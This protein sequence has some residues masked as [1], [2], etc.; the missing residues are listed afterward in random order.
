MM[1]PGKVAATRRRASSLTGER[2][3]RDEHLGGG[4]RAVAGGQAEFARVG[5]VEERGGLEGHEGD[6]TRRS[7]TSGTGSPPS[8]C[9]SMSCS[10]VRTQATSANFSRAASATSSVARGLCA[11]NGSALARQQG[12]AVHHLGRE[13]LGGG[14]DVDLAV[15]GGDDERGTGGRAPAKSPTSWSTAASSA[16]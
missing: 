15:V 14:S 9:S 8:Q 6:V 4:E 16:S 7:A 5:G 3:E 10:R 1:P 13:H 11:A 2:E 12:D